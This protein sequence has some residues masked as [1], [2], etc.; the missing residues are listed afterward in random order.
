MDLLEKFDLCSTRMGTFYAANVVHAVLG[1]LSTLP[2]PFVTRELN[3]NH[4]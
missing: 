3:L 4:F 1:E 2:S